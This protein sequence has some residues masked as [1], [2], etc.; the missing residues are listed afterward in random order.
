VYCTNE[1]FEGA[2]IYLPGPLTE[3]LKDNYPEIV[4][5]TNY[6]HW[7]RKV[8]VGDKS[9]LSTG[10]YVD[11]SF[12]EMFTFPFIKGNPL[13]ALDNPNSIVIIEDLAGRFFGDDDPLGKTISYYI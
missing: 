6:K 5:A 3:Y 1:A 10:S 4:R 12:F 13:T 8:A 2:A 11:P 9:Y 7:K